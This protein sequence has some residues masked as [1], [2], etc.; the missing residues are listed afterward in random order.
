MRAL[1]EKSIIHRDL[2]LANI[3]VHREIGNIKEI[4]KIADLGF[5][6][7]LKHEESKVDLNLGSLGTKAPEIVLQ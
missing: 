4:I 2:K 1:H 3:L 7:I 6:H 5:C